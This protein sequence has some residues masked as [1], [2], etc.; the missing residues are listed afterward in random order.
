MAEQAPDKIQVK[1][2]VLVVICVALLIGF[3]ILLSGN[4]GGNAKLY[5]DVPTSSALKV[6]APVKVAGVDA[7]KIANVDYRGG[8]IDPVLQRPVFVRITLAL[9]EDKLATLK[10]SSRFTITTLGILGEKY[11]EISPGLEGQPIPAET[12]ILGDE[13]LGMESLM[14]N[15]GRLM[16]TLSDLVERNGEQLDQVIGNANQALA[17]ARRAVETV[18]GLVTRVGPNLESV[19]TK[20]ERIEDEVLVAVASV[21]TALGDGTEIKRLIQN[22]SGVA[23]EIRAEVK[24]LTTAVKRT[25]SRYENVGET[26]EKLIGELEAKVSTS[27]KE[28]EVILGDVKVVTRQLKEGE[29]TIGALLSDREMYDDVRE[30]MKDLKR[31]P[32]KFIWKE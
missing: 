23:S 1:V 25:L 29:G 8:A 4:S 19:V 12:I 6:G 22:T 21:N 18:E 24:P 11:V 32:W 7:G 10:D 5:L 2:G 27:L 28:L 15:A 9:N 16:S 13:P 14:S 26:A 3:V 31:H 20:A 17:S 30:L